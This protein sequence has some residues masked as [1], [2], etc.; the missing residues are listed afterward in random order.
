MSLLWWDNKR[1]V[2]KLQNTEIIMTN[3]I[4]NYKDKNVIRYKEKGVFPDNKD[5]GLED[6][7][8]EVAEDLSEK[9]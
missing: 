1:K 9:K 6:G 8:S 3:Q 4:K 2:Y 7:L 5:N